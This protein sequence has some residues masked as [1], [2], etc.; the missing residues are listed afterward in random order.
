LPRLLSR[1][2]PA[3]SLLDI[4]DKTAGDWILDRLLMLHSEHGLI[5]SRRPLISAQRILFSLGSFIYI[6]IKLRS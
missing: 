5:T 1:T 3:R 2:A 6:S 4:H